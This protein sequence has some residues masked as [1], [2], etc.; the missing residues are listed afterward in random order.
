[1]QR[2]AFRLFRPEPCR[3]LQAFLFWL[4]RGFLT[5]IILLF[6]ADSY[7]KLT[8]IPILLTEKVSKTRAKPLLHRRV[9]RITTPGIFYKVQPTLALAR[10]HE[11]R[12]E[13]CFPGSGQRIAA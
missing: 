8:P 5:R 12:P 6:G 3:S 13:A 4:Y 9:Q 2:V 10:F 11:C 7:K 1:M